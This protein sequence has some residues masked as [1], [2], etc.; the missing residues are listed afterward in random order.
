MTR[1]RKPTALITGVTGFAGSYL[2]EELLHNGFDVAGTVY[3]SEPTDNIETIKDRLRLF[4][5]DVLDKTWCRRLVARLRPDYI[6]HLA[7]IASVSESFRNETLTFEINFNGTIN[8]LS[9]CVGM[10][11]LKKFV[12]VGSS[13][14]Y[15]LVGSKGRA[16]TEEQPFNPVSPYGISKAAAEYACRHFFRQHRL[17]VVIVRAF[18][19]SGPRQNDSYVIPAFARQIAAIEAGRQRPVIKV[20]DLSARRDLSDVRDVVCGYRLAARKGKAGDVYQLCSG[21]AVAISRVLEMM[22][23]MSDR[24]ITVKVDRKRM[25]KSD[26]PVLRGSRRKA[27]QQL[28]FR[29]RY[30]LK[31]TLRNT[32]DYWRSRYARG[33]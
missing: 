9:A 31:D 11:R 22:L 26:L 5:L 33:R 12:F 18:N 30:K 25:R 6:F 24:V 23:A 28:G 8:M 7:A 15:G 2:A 17:P 21:R 13:D 4:P 29:S 19:H 1:V 10:K 14:S 20:G 16:L 27:T 3:N 32:L